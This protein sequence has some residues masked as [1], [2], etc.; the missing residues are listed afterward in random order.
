MAKEGPILIIDD[1]TDDHETLEEI[2]RE[3]N[4]ENK[5]LSFTRPTEAFLYLKT[6]EDKPFIIFCDVNLPEQNGVEF[7]RQIDGDPELR[8][9]SIPFVFYSTSVDQRSVNIAYTE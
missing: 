1:D 8:R 4:V 7:K 5:L 9:K 3:L 6:T 2:F